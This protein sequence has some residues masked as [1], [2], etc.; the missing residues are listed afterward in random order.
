MSK[1]AITA[2]ALS[3]IALAAQPASAQTAAEGTPI[4]LTATVVGPLSQTDL[5]VVTIC[6]GFEE[7]VRSYELV[8]EA[9]GI[10]D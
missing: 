2:L 7:R 10:K 9:C 3:F 4:T 5:S 1:F 8:A 6:Y